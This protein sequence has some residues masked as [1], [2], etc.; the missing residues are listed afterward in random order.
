MPASSKTASAAQTPATR[1][2]ILNMLKREGE[3]CASQIGP[4]LGVTPMAARLQLYALEAEGLV[5]ARS[6]AKGRGRPLKIWSLTE[7]SAR[8]FPD[9]HQSLAVEMIQ[10]VEELFGAEGLAKFVKKHGDMQRKAYGEKLAKAKTLGERVKGLAKARTDEGYMA[11]AKKDGR[12]W[13]LIENHCP[14]CSAAKACT[15]LCAGELKVFSDVL[16]KDVKVTREEHILA[17]A[18]RCAYRVKASST[19]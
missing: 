13:L 11:E 18:R 9:A 7:A 10:S 15:G 3:L 8:V 19:A 12:D 17:G 5:E 6:E 2:A 16:G 1:D 14:I 4:A